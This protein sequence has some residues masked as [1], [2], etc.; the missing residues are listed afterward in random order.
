MYYNIYYKIICAF[1][2]QIVWIEN[3]VFFHNFK[4]QDLYT[5]KS[6]FDTNIF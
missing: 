3:Y 4:R 2:G 6:K 5:K 1:H